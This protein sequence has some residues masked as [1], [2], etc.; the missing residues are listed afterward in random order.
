V[1]IHDD[2]LQVSPHDAAD[3]AAAHGAV[4]TTTAGKVTA[5]LRIATGLLFLWAF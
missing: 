5:V 4:M 3:T 1:S 2:S